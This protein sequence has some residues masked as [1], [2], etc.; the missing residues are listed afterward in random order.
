M[1]KRKDTGVVKKVLSSFSKNQTQHSYNKLIV[2]HKHIQLCT[3]L[4]FEYLLGKIIWIFKCS[5]R[6]Q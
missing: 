5:L 2:R 4:A 3:K 6:V 1:T